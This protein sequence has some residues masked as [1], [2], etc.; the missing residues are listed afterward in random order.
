[1]VIF[2][3]ILHIFLSIFELCYIQNCVVMN[4]EIKRLMCN[5]IQCTYFTTAMILESYKFGCCREVNVVEGLINI[6]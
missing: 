4:C 1:M 5:G 6:I 3:Y 2:L